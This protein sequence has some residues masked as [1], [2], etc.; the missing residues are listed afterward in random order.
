MRTSR[1][2]AVGATRMRNGQTPP[3]A[4][5]DAGFTLAEL[6]FAIAIMII[7]LVAVLGALASA[8]TSSVYSSRRARALTIAT[9][10][11]EWARN[12][13]YDAIGVP[14]GE[15]PGTIPKTV[16]IEGYSV[17]TTVTWARDSSED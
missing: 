17:E 16:N 4:D 10:R 1:G 5:P 9:D 2:A 8:T 11:I 12:M 6:L 3:R 14:G 15:P 7:V 13:E